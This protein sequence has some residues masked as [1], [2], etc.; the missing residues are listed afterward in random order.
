MGVET[1]CYPNTMCE[2]LKG[3][4]EIFLKLSCSK[5]PSLLPFPSHRQQDRLS[6][7]SRQ[8]DSHP[9][10]L[11]PSGRFNQ[12]AGSAPGAQPTQSCTCYGTMALP[13]EG[14]HHP[15]PLCE[16][17][18]GWLAAQQ[19]EAEV[20]QVISVSEL[21]GKHSGEASIGFFPI[22]FLP[23][24]GAQ[25]VWQGGRGGNSGIYGCYP[26]PWPGEGKSFVPFSHQPSPQT[27]SAFG[28]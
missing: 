5:S 8:E 28:F 2:I 3:L 6:T 18:G 21:R 23:S 17:R 7:Y 13:T 19:F 15:P 14:L 27:P 10:L 12:A 16:K 1:E 9:H 4:M 26:L 24:S 22:G 11:P 20:T 25:Q